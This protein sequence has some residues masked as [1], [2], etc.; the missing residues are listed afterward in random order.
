MSSDGRDERGRYAPRHPDEE[1]L[2]AVRER[3]P[4]GTAEVADTVGI[5]RQ[6][7]DYRL[8]KLA[9]VGRVRSKKVGGSLVW[10]LSEDEP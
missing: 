6:S 7:A 2:N 8:R 10:S 4:A 5:A 9:D 1:I 3:E